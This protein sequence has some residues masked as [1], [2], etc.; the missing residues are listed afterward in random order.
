MIAN[1]NL[2]FLD[3]IFPKALFLNVVRDPFLNAQSLL[4][5]RERFFDDRERWYSFKPPEYELLKEQPVFEQV[6]GQIYHTRAGVADGLK[7]VAP[8]RKLTIDYSDFCANPSG[9]FEAIQARLHDQG[10]ALEG[11]HGGP[12]RF[13]ES[14][15]VRLSGTDTKALRAAVN[16]YDD[17]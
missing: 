8:S 11:G 17:W 6:V 12:D 10:H 16:A 5:A 2:P 1:W 9:T 7:N 15:T 3:Q 4:Q 13:R 14:R